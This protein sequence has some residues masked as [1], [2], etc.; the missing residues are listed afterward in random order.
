MREWIASDRFLDSAVCQGPAAI[1]EIKTRKRTLVNP[2]PNDT[3]V[4]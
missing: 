2:D 3:N 4:V 1:F